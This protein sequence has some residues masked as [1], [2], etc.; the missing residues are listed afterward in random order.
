[1]YT[2]K[3]IYSYILIGNLFYILMLQI[4][5]NCSQYKIYKTD[6]VNGKTQTKHVWSGFYVLN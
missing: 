3:Y 6:S 1:M 5:Q 2:I 4:E